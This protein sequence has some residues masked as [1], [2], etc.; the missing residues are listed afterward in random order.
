[1]PENTGTPATTDQ[2]LRS[3]KRLEQDYRA[4]VRDY[5]GSLQLKDGETV[6]RCRRRLRQT[7]LALQ[8]ARNRLALFSLDY[9]YLSDEYVSE[10]EW[11]E[12]DAED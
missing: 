12:D 9:P 1:M 5:V 2:A 7:G 4:A 6:G 10:R 11:P 8:H 3:V